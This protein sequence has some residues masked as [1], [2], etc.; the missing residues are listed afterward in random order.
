MPIL[1]LITYI[2]GMPISYAI[3]ECFDDTT[4]ADNSINLLICAMWPA[5]LFMLFLAIALYPTYWLTKK[6]ITIFKSYQ[7]E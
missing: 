1:F 6:L 3:I 2:I 7:N 5:M 4:E